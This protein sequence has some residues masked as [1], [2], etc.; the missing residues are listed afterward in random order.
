MKTINNTKIIGIDHGYGNIKTANHCFKSG[1]AGYD[2]E[3]LLQNKSQ[4]WS[5]PKGHMEVGETEEETAIREIFEEIG[6]T[7]SLISGFRESVKYRI[8]DFINREVILFLCQTNSEP[9]IRESEIA[10]Y[11]W[12]NAERAKTL[13]YPE[14]CL[15]IDKLEEF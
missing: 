14:Y 8:A 15:M 10:E 4:T 1:I 2:S 7:A 11:R 5:F 3:P 6:L 12:V 9:A 13:L